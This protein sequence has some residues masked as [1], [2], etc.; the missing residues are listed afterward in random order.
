MDGGLVVLLPLLITMMSCICAA[1]DRLQ[2]T[3][4]YYPL[5]SV[6]CQRGR[7]PE[8]SS[9]IVTHCYCCRPTQATSWACA[10]VSSAAKPGL[11]SQ[12]PE[13]LGGMR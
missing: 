12:P 4:S 6:G 5:C 3:P 7:A 2:S 8:K 11:E 1:L 10:S 9:D 13:A